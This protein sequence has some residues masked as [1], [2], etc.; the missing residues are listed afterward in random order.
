MRYPVIRDYAH[1]FSVEHMCLV[2]G[3]RRSGYYA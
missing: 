2:L 1:E 3:V